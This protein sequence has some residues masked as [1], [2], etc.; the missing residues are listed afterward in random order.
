[1]SYQIKLD[2][3]NSYV[4]VEVSGTRIPGQIPQN[5]LLVWQE[6]AS[7][8]RKHQINHVLAVFNLEGQRTVT[9]TLKIFEGIKPW[10]WPELMM[11]YINSQ[12]SYQTN[13]AIIEQIA[14]TQGITFQ[15]FSSEQQGIRWLEK[16]QS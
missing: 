15:A 8:C 7:A 1:M 3:L 10:V 11:A 13:N 5:T 12:N 9:D 16:F 2:V 4:R 14:R 6:V